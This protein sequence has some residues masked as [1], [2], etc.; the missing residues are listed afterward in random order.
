MAKCSTLQQ[1]ASWKRQERADWK[2]RKAILKW[3]SDDRCATCAYR[4]GT[5]A[6]GD[7]VDPGLTRVRR[8]LL[9]AAQPFYCHDTCPI[10]G[11]PRRLCIGHMDAMSRRTL[12]GYYDQHPAGADDVQAELRAALDERERL[13]QE[14]I[15]DE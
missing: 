2:K 3:S 4:P 6:S 15:E 9:N 10:P 8:A 11:G 1:R 5:E 12:A 7:E 14:K 13:F